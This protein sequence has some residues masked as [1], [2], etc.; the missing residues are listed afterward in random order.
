MTDCTISRP[1]AQEL[2]DRYKQM[3]ETT[4]LG[5]ATIIEESNEWYAVAV[6]YA[7][8]EEFYAIAE[9]AQKELDPRFACTDNLVAMAERDG[10]FPRAA[11]PAQGYLKL[12]GTANA[13]LT[14]PLEFTVDGVQYITATTVSQ[15]T[16]L[17]DNGSAVIRVRAVTPGSAGNITATT[18]TLDTAVANVNTAVEVC[19]GSF[20]SGSDAEETE[21]FRTRYINRL[22]YRP[23]ATVE[24]IKDKLLEWPCATRA[25]LREGS[26]CGCGCEDVTV[27]TGSTA[28]DCADCG[29]VECGGKMNFY[30]LF[31]DSF[32]NGIAPE[33]TLYEIEEWMFGSPQGYGMGQV[34]MGVCGKIVPVTA[35]Q[36]DVYVDILDCPTST[37]L[38][39][40][41]T[42]VQ[43]FFKTVEP[44]KTVSANSLESAVTRII[45]AS[46]VDVRME[47]VNAADG[48]GQ[49][50]GASDADSKV[51][52]T[53]CSLEPDCDYMITL[54]EIIITRTSD[55]SGSCP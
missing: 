38:A 22:K 24:W 18:G 34:E 51:Y 12:T 48:Y 20:C 5:G 4:V 31:D 19:G 9:Q 30:V 11:V 39:N 2:F 15:P 47:L 52:V 7:M 14:A 1:T 54:N 32:D 6:N 13:P 25:V 27:T 44:S 40:V 33:T 36:V 16:A 49:S 42:T 23:R 53:G 17:D 28:G 35:V 41:R 37:D 55:T 46:D 29:C 43:E 26:C 21:A 3:F 50:Y 10:V 45:G 8:G